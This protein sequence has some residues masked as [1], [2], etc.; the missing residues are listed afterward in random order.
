MKKKYKFV[1]KIHNWLSEFTHPNALGS[2]L[3]FSKINKQNQK[4][5]FYKKPALQDSLS[6]A[7]EAA[8]LFPVFCD[9]WENYSKIRL[10]IKK[11]WKA[12]VDVCDLFEKKITLE[13]EKG[14]VLGYFLGIFYLITHLI[15]KAVAFFNQK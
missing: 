13:E 7:L 15:K 12:S 1:M 11:E 2:C 5:H 10:Q 6:P 14:K 8:I 4:V 3:M 9:D